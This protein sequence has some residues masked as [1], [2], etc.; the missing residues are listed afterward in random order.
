VNGEETPIIRTNYLLRG[1]VVP[2]GQSKVEMRF[3]PD[4][5]LGTKNLVVAFQYLIVLFL[6]FGVGMT[7][8]SEKKES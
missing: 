3:E 5:Y 2:A 1:I 6:L 8:Y 7:I 4:S